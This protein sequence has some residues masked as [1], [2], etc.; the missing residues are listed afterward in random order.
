MKNDKE[1]KDTLGSYDWD[2]KEET[3]EKKN[4]DNNS[5]TKK[6]KDSLG[7]YDW[8]VDE[9]DKEEKY[10]NQTEE[11]LNNKE[12]KEDI[13]GKIEK[14]NFFKYGLI[15]IAI[16]VVIPIFLI[17]RSKNNK[18][19]AEKNE[20]EFEE[21]INKNQKPGLNDNINI[22]DENQKLGENKPEYAE[23][24]IIEDIDIDTEKQLEKFKS[25]DKILEE[26]NEKEKNNKEKVNKD[27]IKELLNPKD[28]LKQTDVT[29]DIDNNFKIKKTDE[30]IEVITIKKPDFQMKITTSKPNSFVVV[31]K[32]EK[33]DYG[34]PPQSIIIKTN[35]NGE[36]ILKDNIKPGIEIEYY[37]HSS[38]K[39]NT[40]TKD[41]EILQR[42]ENDRFNKKTIIEYDDPEYN[43]KLQETQ[44]YTE[45]LVKNVKDLDNN[46][47]FVS[48]MMLDIDGSL[49]I[50]IKDEI[51]KLDK[52]TR[53]KR[54]DRYVKKALETV[55]KEEIKVKIKRAGEMI[56]MG[57]ALKDSNN[58]YEWSN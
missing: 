11:E 31:E 57:Q 9:K 58:N 16:I 12:I 18:K 32:I 22:K 24:R 5:N 28:E 2:K 15:I 54:I 33:E 8:N 36:Y 49:I 14:D 40:K 44:K 42:G 10:K 13:E 55:K 46:N 20:K 29:M 3:K 23:G 26:Q 17:L 52:A 6:K 50:E 53:N 27:E 38:I 35:E 41:Y 21:Q 56:G 47:T 34:N 1:K 4:V 51:L 7:S 25:L 37:L 19:I 48:Y 30:S 45:S 43:K 39:I